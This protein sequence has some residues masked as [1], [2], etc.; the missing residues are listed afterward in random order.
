MSSHLCEHPA[1]RPAAAVDRLLADVDELAEA[2]L[3]PVAPAELGMLVK[4]IETVVRRLSAEGLRVVAEADRC[5]VSTDGAH[6][7]TAA[8]L[9]SLLNIAPAEAHRRA[10]LAEAL[11][12][13]APEG[14]AAT[15][16]AVTEDAVTE[17]DGAA[18]A[19]TDL[20]PTRDAL[21]SGSIS[22]GHASVVVDAL[23][24]LSPPHTPP[25]LLDQETRHEAQTLLLEHAAVLDPA[26]LGKAARHLRATLDPDAADRLAKHE[27]RQAETRGFGITQDSTGMWTPYGHLTPLAGAALAAALDPLAAPRPAEDG[28]PDPRTAAQ[29][30]HDALQ[31]LAEEHLAADGALPSSHGTPTRLVVT[32]EA[33][34]LL[35]D[36]TRNDCHGLPGLPGLPGQVGIAP[37]TLPGG[38]PISALAAQVLA[39]DAELVAVLVDRDGS[40]LDVGDSVYLFPPRIRQAVIVRDQHCTFAGCTAP[41]SWCQVHHL[42]RF[43]DGGPTS[44]RNGALLCGRHHRYVHAVGATGELVNGRV[45]WTEPGRSSPR[46]PPPA[47]TRAIR[48]L[49]RRAATRIAARVG[50]DGSLLGR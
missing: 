9:R 31:R 15:A 10:D 1:D 2:E 25:G 5:G 29:R 38:W 3:W 23:A 6:G 39:C 19:P 36:L 33:E 35:A 49:G 46:L 21:L 20:A 14:D 37:A 8:W 32:V 27:D 42:E 24:H 18:D 47:V 30:R 16:D 45:R 7:S 34:T 48:H 22:P 40:P 28:T 11:F 50:P 4:G 41:A 43:R 12:A 44:E 26:M 17:D 13:G